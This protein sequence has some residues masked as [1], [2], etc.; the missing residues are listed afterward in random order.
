MKIEFYK[1][2]KWLAQFNIYWGVGKRFEMLS[3][4]HLSLSPYIKYV[5]LHKF[6][7]GDKH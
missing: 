5:M 3:V 2:E 7:A 6:L 1:D 4:K